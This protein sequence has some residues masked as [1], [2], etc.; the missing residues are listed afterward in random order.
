M[1]S[2]AAVAWATVAFVG[3]S[4]PAAAQVGSAAS[5]VVGR[6]STVSR[7][8]PPS[9]ER[10][11]VPV[12]RTGPLPSA[13]SLPQAIEEAAARSPAITAAQSDVAAAEARVRQSGF[14][15]NPEISFE[16]ENVAGTGELRGVRSAEAT[17][18]VNQRLDLGGRRSARVEAA[19]AAYA[20]QQVRLAIAMADLL[21]SVREQFARAIAT[22]ERLAQATETVTRAGGLARAARIL[23]EAGRDP[24]LR[25]LRAR[26]ALTLAEAQRSIAEAEEVTARTSLAALFGIGTP[27]GSV[28]SGKLD[29]TPVHFDPA[30]SLDVRLADAERVAAQAELRQQLTERSLEPAVGVGIRHVRETGDFGLVAGVSMPLRVFDK[31]QGNIEAARSALAGAQARRASALATTTAGAS[32]AIANVQSAQRRVAALE[33]AGLGEASEVLRLAQRSYAEGRATLLELLDAQNAYTAAAT[34]LTEARLSLALA[35]AELGRF[36]AGQE[37]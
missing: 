1:Q 32:N 22:R 18:T 19:R 33:G 12:P 24:P 6:P 7:A 16:L 9:P 30:N 31:N 26:A 10:L 27:V 3:L 29:L 23:V 36:F 28:T 35:T 25:A 2:V 13:L 34:A 15:S 8:G 20:V 21:R 4:F 14:R 17:L 11:T 5:P 37:Q